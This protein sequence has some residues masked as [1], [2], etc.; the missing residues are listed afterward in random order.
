MYASKTSP[1]L[2]TLEIAGM[3]L[4]LVLNL[5]SLFCSYSYNYLCSLGSMTTIRINL[6]CCHPAQGA[7]VS[8]TNVTDA[9]MF[10][11]KTLCNTP[12]K[13]MV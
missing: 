12:L 7:K 13:L 2:Y 8:T 5:W 10:A 9:G 11:S 1:M 6:K 3:V 4:T